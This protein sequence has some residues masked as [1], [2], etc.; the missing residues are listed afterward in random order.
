MGAAQDRFAKLVH[1]LGGHLDEAARSKVFNSL[2]R[3]CASN[4]RGLTEKYRNNVRGFLN[5]AQ[6]K[7]VEQAEYDE[8]TGTIRIVDKGKS[9]TCPLVK[10]GTTPPEFCNCTLGWQ[11]ATYSILLGKPVKAEIE[12]S[13][14]RGGK[15][16]V[17]RIRTI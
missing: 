16:C 6:E 8:A 15:R 12:E 2:G 7:W 1:I 14:L 17:F 10:V 9:C 5:E 4:Y 11:E 3:E 13:I